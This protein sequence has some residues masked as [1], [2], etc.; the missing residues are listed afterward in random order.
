MSNRT[1]S[2]GKCLAYEQMYYESGRMGKCEG[3]GTER[4]SDNNRNLLSLYPFQSVFSL[5]SFFIE[6]EKLVFILLIGTTFL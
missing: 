5:I 2:G 3:W 6:R 1:Y 4:G